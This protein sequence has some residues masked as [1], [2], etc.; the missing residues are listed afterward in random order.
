MDCSIMAFDLIE[1]HSKRAS[2]IVDLEM[3][4]KPACMSFKF[5]TNFTGDVLFGQRENNE[6][7]W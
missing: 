3:Q 6:L 1:R 5:N 7:Q 2:I 4:V